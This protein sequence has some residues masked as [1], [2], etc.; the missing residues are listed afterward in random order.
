MS[1]IYI[2]KLDKAGLKKEGNGLVG[3]AVFSNNRL[4]RWHTTVKLTDVAF[5]FYDIALSYLGLS[6]CNTLHNQIGLPLLAGPQIDCR[7]SRCDHRSVSRVGMGQLQLI[8]DLRRLRLNPN[9]NA[10]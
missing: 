3:I 5:T 2:F 1:K 9:V 8:F 6:F 7:Q 10:N 4:C